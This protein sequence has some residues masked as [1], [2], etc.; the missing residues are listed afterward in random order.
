MKCL[1]FIKQKYIE[2]LLVVL[3]LFGSKRTPFGFVEQEEFYCW[4]FRSGGSLIGE[5]CYL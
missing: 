4:H 2:I 3:G 1:Y 5:S